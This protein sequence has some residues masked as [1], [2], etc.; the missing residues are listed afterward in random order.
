MKALIRIAR[1][2][3]LVLAL[4]AAPALGAPAPAKHW[5]CVPCGLPC[6]AQVFAHPGTCPKCGMALV[7]AATAAAQV[8]AHPRKKV[9]VLVFDGVEIID[10][11]GPWEMFGAA[12]YEVYTVAA[13]KSPVTTAMGMTVVPKYTFADAPAPDVLLVPGGGVRAAS[14][15]QATL[16]WVRA[17]NARDTH[18]F[19]VCNGAFI[20]ASAG[21]LD[22]LTATTT[23]GNLDRL[24]T[25]YPKV[26]VVDD[27]RYADNGHVITAAGLTAGIDGALHVIDRMEG[28]G[29]AEQV[30]LSEEYA[31]RPDAEF[32]RGS[33]AEHELPQVDL[34]S[35][36]RFDVTRT[37]GTKDQ[38]VIEARGTS[39]LG[40]AELLDHV[41]RAV[42]DKSGWKRAAVA[43]AGAG[44]DTRRWTFRGRGGRPWTGTLT[45][46]PVAGHDPEVALAVHVARAG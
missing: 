40:A 25:Q 17:V 3:V 33:L 46:T 19:S 32:V 39:K 43:T 28:R 29:A 2:L 26:H 35:V 20:L 5:V 12:N 4:A 13:S 37:E 24:R 10:Y 14:Q 8:A 41:S 15:D 1:P 22:G 36:G 42:E 9:G 34:D 21:L 18:T 7:D 11:T 31:W 27:R 6:D 38:W 30:A 45:V 23:Y 44:A 16:D